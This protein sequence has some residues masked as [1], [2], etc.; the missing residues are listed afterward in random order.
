LFIGAA[1]PV[2]MPPASSALPLLEPLLEPLLLPD[3]DPELLPEL[4]DELAPEE[5][6]LELAPLL[7]LAPPSSEE[8]SAPSESLPGVDPLPLQPNTVAPAST[9]IPMIVAIF[10]G[11]SFRAARDA[12]IACN[13]WMCAARV[14]RRCSRIAGMQSALDVPGGASGRMGSGDLQIPQSVLIARAAGSK[15]GSNVKTPHPFD[16]RI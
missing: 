12:W 9:Q 4:P 7:L 10:I 6:P 16:S 1:S 13:V 11:S 14:Q 2:T 3:D 15:K 8:L 5:E